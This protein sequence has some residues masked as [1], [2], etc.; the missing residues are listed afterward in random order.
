[1]LLGPRPP[2][3][4]AADQH[5][6]ERVGVRRRGNDEARQP[7]MLR[8]L[9]TCAAS[10]VAPLRRSWHTGGGAQ[11][12][13]SPLIRAQQRRH[14]T[15]I[16]QHRPAAAR[17]ASA[18]RDAREA[19]SLRR[20]ALHAL[21]MHAQ[22]APQRSAAVA[23]AAPPPQLQRSG[24]EGAQLPPRQQGRGA[25]RYART[26]APGACTG[27]AGGSLAARTAIAAL[28]RRAVEVAPAP[29][30]SEAAAAAIKAGAASPT[31]C[32]PRRDASLR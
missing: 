20:A 32:A 4:S 17:A 1:M 12:P 3:P 11:Q 18:R 19:P 27:C 31:Q 10:H 21:A 5:S 29:Q 22:R 16:E 9:R 28:R 8:A 14:G 15:A 25:T 23:H 6:Q 2:P 24:A 13:T 26:F 7:P 30:S